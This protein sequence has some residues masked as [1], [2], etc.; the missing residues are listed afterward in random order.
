MSH[1]EF[2][3]VQQMIRNARYRNSSF[4]PQI[5]TVSDGLLKG[6]VSINPRWA[7]FHADDY[8]KASTAMD[9]TSV[10]ETICISVSGG[11][12]D[13]RGFEFVRAQF[14]EERSRPV[15]S[16]GDGKIQFNVQAVRKLGYT[17]YIEILAHPAHRMIAVRPMEQMEKNALSWTQRKGRVPRPKQM[18]AA[19][20]LPTLYSMFSLDETFAYHLEGDVIRCG[21]EAVL[22]FDIDEA[23]ARIPRCLFME[24]EE[25]KNEKDLG[26]PLG[27]MKSFGEDYYLR[28]YRERQIRETSW[29][30]G[31]A[32]VPSGYG[33]SEGT[34]EEDAR[35]QIRI[36]TTLIK[37]R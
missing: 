9:N 37:I 18:G 24:C 4:L 30:A 25:K 31:K 5:C 10:D 17:P 2:I 3:S 34:D 35:K 6:Y 32:A 20:F 8:A 15:L 26:Y 23:T 7:G 29:N 28:Q 33:I 14:F 11:E 19:A 22:L 16:M 13:M 27:W 36:L 12:A 21:E 1:E